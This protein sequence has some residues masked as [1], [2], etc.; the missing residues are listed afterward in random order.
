MSIELCPTC[1]ES[2]VQQHFKLPG[3]SAKQLWETF[4]QS[5]LS[6]QLERVQE[7]IDSFGQLGFPQC[8]GAIDGSH[9]PIRAPTLNPEDY[10][11]RRSFHSILQAV[12]DSSTCFTDIDI[13]IPG[14]VHDARVLISSKLYHQCQT[15]GSASHDAP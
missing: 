11:N 3:S 5:I 13:G 4:S 10:Y 12:V 14:R 2:V 9:I 6:D 15:V 8:C 1:L 7:V